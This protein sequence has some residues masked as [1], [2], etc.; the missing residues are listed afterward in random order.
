MTQSA[1]Q[2]RSAVEIEGAPTLEG[3]LLRPQDLPDADSRELARWIALARQLRGQFSIIARSA[4]TSVAVTDLSGGYPV[5]L[6]S[7]G[8]G[9]RFGGTL[10]SVSDGS[11]CSL[12]HEAIARLAA[13]GTV[14]SAC[15]LIKGIRTMPGASV[16]ILDGATTTTTGWSDWSQ[17]AQVSKASA[18]DLEEEFRSLL[19][20]W[21]EA[22]LPK[23][24]RVGLLLS[25]GTDSGLLAALMKPILGE[26]LVCITQDYFL[27]RYS[28][29]A[30]A[31]E[32]AERV[33]VPI[34]TCRIGRGDYFRAFRK[35]NS[36]SQNLAVY[37]MEAHNLYCLADFA[38]QRGLD[39]LITGYNADYL[40]LGLGHFFGGLPQGREEYRRAVSSLSVEEKLKWVVSAPRQSSPQSLKLLEALQV[41]PS[42]YSSS[43]DEVIARR[44]RLLEP[45]AGAVTLPTLQQLSGQIDGGIEWQDEHGC[46]AVMRELPGCNFLSPF[47]DPE[48]I[49]FAFRLPTDLIYDGGKTKY[50]LRR[51]LKA[52]TGLERLKRPASMSPIRLWRLLPNLKE[53]ASV[54]PRLSKLHYQLSIENALKRGSL[55][56]DLSK[57]AGLG[58][59]LKSHQI[60]T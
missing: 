18:A 17:V 42:E 23:E 58:I 60:D 38:R 9:P 4:N 25:G 33:G 55:S 12:N 48:I 6:D 20:S 47:Y 27:R 45:L 11:R 52:A 24:G 28:E 35:L 32:T 22:Y 39:T 21:S 5:F 2:T 26:R 49:R 16:S 54:S 30:L 3:R 59:W 8:S 10:Q 19:A 53:H 36:P 13:F 41:S 44:R 7:R 15:S 57:V 37:H 51:L 34:L 50:F 14:G 40:F 46:L 29:R 56:R 1:P 31:V 43:V